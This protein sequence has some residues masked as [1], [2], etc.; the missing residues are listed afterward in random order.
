[1]N[2]RTDILD[3]RTAL[4]VLRGIHYDGVDREKIR[5]IISVCNEMLEEVIEKI[6]SK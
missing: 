4:E 1:M 3:L 5:K 2:H 6:A